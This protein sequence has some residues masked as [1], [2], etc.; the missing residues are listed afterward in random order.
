MSTN[1]APSLIASHTGF[2]SPDNFPGSF[3]LHNLTLTADGRLIGAGPNSIVRVNPD[4][5]MHSNIGSGP[6]PEMGS[7]GKYVSATADS[8]KLMPDNK[9]VVG[10]NW[11]TYPENTPSGYVL[12]RLNA[13]GTLDKTFAKGQGWVATNPGDI[14]DPAGML[15]APDGKFLII[16]TSG[17]G[18]L[19]NQPNNFISLSRFTARG[20]VDLTFGTQGSV[21]IPD[22]NVYLTSVRMQ[23]DGKILAAGSHKSGQWNESVIY[24]INP[25]GS[26]DSS[27]GSGGKAT[28]TFDSPVSA[29][30]AFT[31]QPDGKIVATCWT[32]PA[33][34]SA[35]NTKF[36]VVRL[37]ADGSLDREFGI[38]GKTVVYP[39]PEITPAQQANGDF[40]NGYAESVLVRQDGS[41][42]VAGSVKSWIAGKLL[43]SQFGMVALRPN[44][45]IDSSFGTNGSVTAP[46]R[47]G[48]TI[49]GGTLVEMPDG[50]LLISGSVELRSSVA[51]YSFNADGSPDLNFGAAGAASGNAITYK[52]G[53]AAVALNAGISVH[54]NEL[55]AANYQGASLKLE[56]H[57]GANAA[58]IFEA[59]GK[60]SFA[61]GNVTIGGTVVGTVQGGSGSLRIDFNADASEALVNLV[62]RSI[63]Y[64]NNADLAQDASARI[65]WT[66]SDAGPAGSAPL[67]AKASTEVKL[68][69]GQLP[70]WIEPLLNTRDAA[71]L[72]EELHSYLGV[73][74]TLNVSYLTDGN[75]TPFSPADKEAIDGLLASI[76]AVSGIKFGSDSTLGS[77][78]L[79]IHSST[80]IGSGKM[81][82]AALTGNGGDLYLG[83]PASGTLRTMLPELNQHLL[84]VLGLD[85]D[86][87]LAT[88]LS[89]A[90][91]AALQY[92]YGPNTAVRS[93]NDT[94]KLSELLPHMLWDGG[95]IDTIDGSGLTKDLTLHLEAGHWDYVGSKGAG[96]GS[97]GQITVNYGSIFENANG[98]S[99][100]DRL[101]GTAGDNV[102]RGG[103]GNDTIS[104]NG[105]DDNIDGGNGFDTVNF[106]GKRDAYTVNASAKGFT[107]TGSD[108]LAT[109]NGVERLHF[110]DGEK[111]LDI[112]GNAGQLFRLYQ[113]IFN[114]KPDEAG[115]GYWLKAV[116][117]GASLESVAVEFTKSAEFT[118]MYGANASNKEMLTKIYEYALHR[119]PDNDGF[120][121]WLDV[122]DTK[123]ASLGTV[124][125]GFS[126]SKE[127]YAQVIGSIQHGIDYIA[128]AG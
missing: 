106:S 118:K 29:V 66:F 52:E 39:G 89:Q 72:R 1:T 6:G 67:D 87:A 83:K 101:F 48:E 127:N 102:L 92:L 77:D 53:H 111:A 120:A 58:D 34:Y 79:E 96:I 13:D 17:T 64:R 57:G 128:Y 105:G 8:F 50:R 24:R 104:G 41:I 76:S 95:G 12:Y 55:A 20:E 90:H 9:V 103:A 86:S 75:A 54:D 5:T 112:S 32:S 124:L 80:E 21:L 44:G 122:L 11:N 36:G 125:I 27:F 115:L 78:K 119:Q 15:Q 63:S 113:A 26:L 25:D 69:A 35:I 98:G 19:F 3:F 94:Y 46:P 97:A 38:D 114:R 23:S 60:L 14:E 56:R 40:A 65:D 110:A 37:N 91:I 71:A 88:N 116:D 93:G 33:K 43:T 62:L 81:A 16:G 107:V 42:V 28:F 109:L 18:P 30:E 31:V 84:H 82:Y 51:I 126:E 121:W 59:G 100:N 108:G 99:G 10:G 4:G 73:G 2:T 68:L 7:G 123:K 49:Y 47:D 70:S 117:N 45:E 22:D 85:G 61:G 74:Q